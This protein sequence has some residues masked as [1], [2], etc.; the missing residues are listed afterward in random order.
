VG[1]R[2][3]QREAQSAQRRLAAI[4][5]VGAAIIGAAVVVAAILVVILIVQAH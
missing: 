2:Q 1:G 5:R 4:F 3:R